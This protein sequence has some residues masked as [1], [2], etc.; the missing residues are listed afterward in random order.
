MKKCLITIFIL[1]SCFLPVAKAQFR[2][3]GT[4][5]NLFWLNEGGK[6]ATGISAIAD[7]AFKSTAQCFY[8]GMY[9]P[10]KATY[11]SL[12]D[13]LNI[14]PWNPPNPINVNIDVS[15]SPILVGS[16]YRMAFWGKM[17]DDIALGINFNVLLLMGNVSYTAQTYDKTNYML[18][19][20]D[21]EFMFRPV[22][23]LGIFTQKKLGEGNLMLD[24]NYNF[25]TDFYESMTVDS[26]INFGTL[27]VS[28]SYLFTLSGAN[29]RRSW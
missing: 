24:V 29:K 17:E 12:A 5:N 1:S 4:L 27:Q 14:N 19:V 13:P 25:D 15:V 16:S 2:L 23:G 6:M 26:G 9:F 20:P 10:I 8:V 3:G 7:G 22:G 28:L 11:S 21:D 18:S